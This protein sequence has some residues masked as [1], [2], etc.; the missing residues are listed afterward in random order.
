MTTT[1][2]HADSRCG[3]RPSTFRTARLP[4]APTGPGIARPIDGSPPDLHG[5]QHH[6]T[7]P[8]LWHAIGRR[9]KIWAVVNPA[10]VHESF[11]KHLTRLRLSV[12]V[13]VVSVLAALGNGTPV[14]MV[15]QSTEMPKVAFLGDSY[16]AGSGSSQPEKRWSS[17]VSTRESWEEH[18]FGVPKTGYATDNSYLGRLAEII[19]MKPDIV[20]IS[21]GINDWSTLNN[22]PAALFQAVSN[23][24]A[25]VRGGLP[26]ATIVGVGPSFTGDLTSA[27][28]AFDQAVAEA[29]NSVGGV[30]VSL[31]APTA[32]IQPEMVLSDRTHVND[33]GHAAIA[34]RVISVLST[35]A[36]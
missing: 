4:A 8:R 34:N 36:K 10:S 32:V 25:Q 7:P 17:I 21:G 26:S 5:A 18:N 14:N 9:G 19:A 29:T 35:R 1:P 13:V 3:T 23:T 20:V 12:V 2:P 27:R 15:D 16:T 33:D 30:Y 24:F 11:I 28:I 22:D 6:R 31:I